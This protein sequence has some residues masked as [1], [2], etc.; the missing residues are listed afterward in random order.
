MTVVNF[1]VAAAVQRMTTRFGIGALLV[2]GTALTMAGM[3][4]LAHVDQSSVY[5]TGV[6]LPMVLIGAGQGLAFA[7][8]TSFGLAGASAADAGAASGP[9]N[10]AHQL[11]TAAGLAVLVAASA[12]VTDLTNRVSTA[13]TW[14]SGL[15]AV[16]LVVALAVIVP[17][18]RKHHA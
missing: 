7:P 6:A 4:W 18:E 5:L 3:A 14:G 8:L 16:S 1:A 2:A 11:G 13:L 12:S 9:V 15:L 10:T 17:A